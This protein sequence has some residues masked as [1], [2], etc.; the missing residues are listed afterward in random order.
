MQLDLNIMNKQITLL[1]LSLVLI[2]SCSKVKLEDIQ[3]SSKET[4]SSYIVNDDYPLYYFLPNNY[5]EENKYPVI[6]LLDGDWHTERVAKEISQLWKNKVIPACILVGIGNSEKR[7]RDYTFP[8]DKHN[9]GSGH[10]DK[11]Y[12][13]LRDEL[14]PHVESNYSIDSTQRIIAGHSLGGYFSL[15]SLFQ[16][17]NETPLFSGFI[18]ASASISWVNGYLFGLE[19]QLSDKLDD[20]NCSLYLSVGSD[21]GV[22]TNVL[23]EEMYE[24][25][26]NQ[27]Y[28][29]FRAEHKVFKGKAHE[30]VSIPGFIE[31]LKF[32][33]NK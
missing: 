9:K 19:K 3:I 10:A 25:L 21:E 30:G 23:I 22:S 32:N 24:R 14:L 8:A 20:L 4:I 28:P 5:T 13:F 17:K 31:G 2:N 29:N 6:Y 7:F 11:F 18:A 1:L 12:M 26:K 16:S 27:N 15:Y 33:L